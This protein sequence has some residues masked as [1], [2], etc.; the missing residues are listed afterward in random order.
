M[1]ETGLTKWC[2]RPTNTM[3]R[4]AMAL[5]LVAVTGLAGG[6]VNVTAPDKPIVIN[7]NVKISAEVVLRLDGQAKELIQSNPSIF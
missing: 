7:L 3:M 6:C 2:G 1:T 5:G 4:R